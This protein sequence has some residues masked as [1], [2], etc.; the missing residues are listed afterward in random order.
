M[1]NLR[2]GSIG[3]FEPDTDTVVGVAAPSIPAVAL[4]SFSPLYLCISRVS[5]CYDVASIGVRLRKI[6]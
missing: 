5:G 4:V 3:G 2:N 6:S 1:P